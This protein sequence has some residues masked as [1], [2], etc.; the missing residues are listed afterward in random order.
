MYFNIYSKM[1]AILALRMID[2]SV[3][4][5]ALL[6]RTSRTA[7][8]YYLRVEHKVIFIVLFKCIVA[9]VAYG[10]TCYSGMSQHFQ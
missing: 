8:F 10:D 2:G 6:T 9:S 1:K 4:L 3:L 7:G 5:I